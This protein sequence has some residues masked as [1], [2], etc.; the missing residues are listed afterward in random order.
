MITDVFTF[1]AN[2]R[3]YQSESKLKM[4]GGGEL[5]KSSSS[6]AIC[7]SADSGVTG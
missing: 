7:L 3:W 2:G 1:T 6:P 4:F 5:G